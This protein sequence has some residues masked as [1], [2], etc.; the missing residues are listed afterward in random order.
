LSSGVS[1]YK[2]ISVKTKNMKNIMRIMYRLNKNA[3][4]ALRRVY[5]RSY[6]LLRWRL[7][8]S[9]FCRNVNEKYSLRCL[10]ESPI[11]FIVWQQG[12]LWLRCCCHS[13]AYIAE[14]SCVCTV[15]TFARSPRGTLALSSR[16]GWR[17]R[18]LKFPSKAFLLSN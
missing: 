2:Y 10:K 12:R 14:W 18:W 15:S 4:V 5:I 6:T 3:M 17:T 13:I 8:T 9:S 16:Q 1:I 11:N 7:K